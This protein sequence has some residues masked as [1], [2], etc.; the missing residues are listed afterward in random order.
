MPYTKKKIIVPCEDGSPGYRCVAC[1]IIKPLDQFKSAGTNCKCRNCHNAYLREWARRPE[2]AQKIKAYRDARS[3]YHKAY[4]RE[5]HRAR[6][7][8]K[9]HG[10]TVHHRR[11]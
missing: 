7:F 9:R 11:L 5:W 3:E 8:A 1:G 6:G 4:S 10:I 2:N